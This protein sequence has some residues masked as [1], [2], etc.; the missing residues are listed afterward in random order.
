MI[1]LFLPDGSPT[2][3]QSIG[4]GFDVGVN[5][6]YAQ[7][8]GPRVTWSLLALDQIELEYAAA[9]FPLLGESGCTSPDWTDRACA[10][11]SQAS[12]A[13]DVS[14]INVRTGG[15][16]S[17]LP[18]RTHGTWSTAAGFG[19][20]LG[21][22]YTIDD[23]ASIHAEDEP[24]AIEDQAQWHTYYGGRLVGDI[25]SRHVGFRGRLELIRYTEEVMG[26]LETKT[27]AF[28]GIDA[29]YRF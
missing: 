2:V 21:T 8:E 28:V 9:W 4:V 23:L 27:P 14:R 25:H 19:I 16:L 22:V 12:V 7:R 1:P 11:M 6:P 17:W 24:E 18:L 15:V 29:Y 20:A 10:L 3:V 5:D 26:T 13:P